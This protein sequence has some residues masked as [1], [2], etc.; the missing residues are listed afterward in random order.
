MLFNSWTRKQK[1]NQALDCSPYSITLLLPFLK[2]KVKIIICNKGEKELQKC[3]INSSLVKCFNSKRFPQIYASRDCN[4]EE[5]GRGKKKQKQ[6]LTTLS[7]RDV[8][9]DLPTSDT[10]KSSSGGGFSLNT[11]LPLVASSGSSGSLRLKRSQESRSNDIY[12][13]VPQTS[14]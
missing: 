3:F 13:I 6:K 12:N 5:G 9:T 4:L 8:V 1:T 7:G 2:E 14:L 11:S 10:A